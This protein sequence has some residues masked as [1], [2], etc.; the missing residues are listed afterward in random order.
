VRVEPVG[1]SNRNRFI[2]YCASYGGEHDESYLP[3]S[4]RK[5]VVRMLRHE[6]NLATRNGLTSIYLSVNGENDLAL[7]LYLSEGFKLEKTVVC[8]S[9]NVCTAWLRN[10]V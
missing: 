8:Y 7:G 9:R 6:I 4:V 5:V 2:E 3:G 1:R 10:R